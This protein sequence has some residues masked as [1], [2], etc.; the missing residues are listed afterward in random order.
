MRALAALGLLVG[1]ASCVIIVEP[2]GNTPVPIPT[3]LTC[4]PASEAPRVHLFF[5]TRIERSTVNLAD[6]Y[7]E[8]MQDVAL[9]LAAIGADVTTGV[10]VRQDERWVSRPILAAWGCT[11]DSPEQLRPSDVIRHYAIEAPPEDGNLGCAVDP[12]VRLGASLTDAVTQYPPGL[13]GTNGRRVF[14]LAPDLVLVVHIDSVGRK[15]GYDEPGCQDAADAFAADE[16]GI[17]P[18]LAYQSSMPH[19]RIV[20]WF[21][22]TQELVTRETFVAA[23]K[24]VEGFPSSVLDTLEESRKALYGPLGQTVSGRGASVGVLPLCNMLVQIEERKFLNG[25]L[26]HIANLLGLSFDEERLKTIFEGGL[27]ELLNPPPAGGPAPG[28]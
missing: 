19:D 14:G 12:L 4:N 11:L 17:A 28:G 6:R 15:T 24:S 21:F 1:T 8:M 23:C 27:E 22:T 10:L 16:D 3:P 5:A 7:S 26:A 13:N 20:H 2:G 25:Q 18:W 9:G